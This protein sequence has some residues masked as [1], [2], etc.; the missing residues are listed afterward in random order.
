MSE[1][2]KVYTSIYSIQ[3]LKELATLRPGTEVECSIGP[4]EHD[5]AYNFNMVD[6]MIGVRVNGR[7]LYRESRQA[8]DFGGVYRAIACVEG[9]GP[10]YSLRA[11]AEE[12]IRQDYSMY[13]KIMVR[14]I[15]ANWVNEAMSLN[16]GQDTRIPVEEKN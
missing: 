11:S 13:E 14:S 1:T 9:V 12:I 16:R 5:G 15:L 10:K 6:I 4:S 7:L 3:A 2:P 8:N